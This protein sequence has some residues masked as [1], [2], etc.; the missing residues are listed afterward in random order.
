MGKKWILLLYFT[1]AEDL[2]FKLAVCCTSRWNA[3]V[4]CTQ[5]DKCTTVFEPCNNSVEKGFFLFWEPRHLIILR[6]PRLSCVLH[7]VPLQC[8]GSVIMKTI[9]LTA[10]PFSL[11]AHCV[12]RS[13]W[14]VSLWDR[15]ASK[16][17]QIIPS[18]LIYTWWSDLFRAAAVAAL[19]WL[20]TSYVHPAAPTGSYAACMLGAGIQA[21]APADCLCFDG[22]H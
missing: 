1:N 11:C 17:D 12:S 5:T 21:R 10:C 7:N 22:Q 13:L 18:P 20:L 3:A 2:N 8:F 19:V 9:Q 4:Y 14:V 6:S 16:N 15:P